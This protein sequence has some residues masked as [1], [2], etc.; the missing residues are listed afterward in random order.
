MFSTNNRCL[1]KLKTNWS[2]VLTKQNCKEDYQRGVNIII[3]LI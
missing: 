1:K 3:T 2:Q